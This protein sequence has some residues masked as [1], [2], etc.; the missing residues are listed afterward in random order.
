M[1]KA[2]K[3]DI[4]NG[5]RRATFPICKQYISSASN[6]CYFPNGHHTCIVTDERMSQPSLESVEDSDDHDVGKATSK[7]DTTLFMTDIIIMDF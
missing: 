5:A 4:P 6:G 2:I 1:N 3:R 7:Y